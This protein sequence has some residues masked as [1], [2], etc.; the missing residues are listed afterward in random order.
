M[1]NYVKFIRG[2]PQAYKNLAPNYDADTLYFICE[3][4]DDD[5]ALYLGAK[6]IASGENDN[7]AFTLN[8]LKD[9]VLSEI[10]EKHILIYDTQKKAWVNI[11]LND[12]IMEFVGAT[13]HSS[14]VAG[15]VPAPA[16][17]KTNLFLRSDGTWA[18][19][20]V[21]TTGSNHV[22]SVENKSDKHEDL[23]K[24]ATLGIDLL[25]G[26]IFVI[27]DNLINDKYQHT[28]YSY[29]GSQWVAL[30]GNYSAENVYFTE[31]FIFTENVG[32]I[33]IPT[34][35]SIVVPAAG[36][37]AKEFLTNIFKKEKNPETE[38]PRA[39]I[40]LVMSQNL[41]EV[42]SIV[43]P[44]YSIEFDQGSYSYNN[45]TGV[46]PSYTITD[47]FGNFSN[48]P[49]GELP[50]FIA[51]DNTNYEISATVNYSDGIVPNTNLGNVYPEG[52]IKA[53][54]IKD[55]KSDAI[56]GY[57]NCFYGAFSEKVEL[58]SDNIRTLLS[59]NNFTKSGDIIEIPIEKGAMR[60]VIAYP[61]TIQ[62][63]SS[64]KDLNAFN[65]EI[66][67]SFDCL[68]TDVAGANNYLPIKYKIYILDYAFGAS[69]DNIYRVTL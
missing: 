23:I 57:R 64:I 49:I 58:N 42:G 7:D 31:D 22:F 51:E 60:V 47:S 69:R 61:E 68:F 54:E 46:V 45:E 63:I 38:R 6:L 8:G 1:A 55:I 44:K 34:S 9:V 16:A 19:I 65:T 24:Q 48:E 52:Q 56:K 41:Y 13:A 32:T 2:T 35:G 33:E 67:S 27:K 66:I 12:V 30:D 10:G 36:L 29:N 59:T 17:G 39:Y 62:D 15:L 3:K 26:D 37:N 43:C 25:S 50:E 40:D 53:G 20:D 28:A 11:D 14:G 5:G 21:L 4:D 18:E